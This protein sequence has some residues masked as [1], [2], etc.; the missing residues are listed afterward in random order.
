MG[1]IIFQYILIVVLILGLGYLIYLVKDRG[2]ELF[3]DYFGLT[4]A[5]LNTLQSDESTKE[6]IKIIL[7]M[8]SQ[9]VSYIEVEFLSMNNVDKEEVALKVC[10]EAIQQYG[11]ESPIDDNSIRYLIRV[12]S[13]M[14][15]TKEDIKQG[16]II[17]D[18]SKE[19]IEK[20][21]KRR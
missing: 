19:V 13:A 8:V 11:F 1:E 2:T 10:R 12:S 3:E 14:N 16:K 4:Y 5:I 15:P 7:R 9:V 17:S 21:I 6:N 18:H 20:I